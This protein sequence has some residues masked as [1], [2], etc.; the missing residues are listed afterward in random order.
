MNWNMVGH[1]WA[2]RVLSEHIARGRSKHAYLF[3]GPQGIGK[4]TL[5]LSFFKAI[6]CLAPPQAGQMCNACSACTRIERMEHPD[7]DLLQAEQE[8]GNLRVDQI[9]AL[10]RNLS[11]TPYEAHYRMA[12]LLRFEE[13]NPHA[14]N[15]LLKTLEEP[16]PQVVL[17]LTAESAE[18]LLPTIVS[19][20]EVVRLGPVPLQIVREGLQNRWDLSAVEADLLAHLSGGRVGYALQ[21]HN[22]PEKLEQRQSW[23]ND[24]SQ[25]IVSGRVA[26][27][28]YVE[29]LVKDK[30]T[31]R[32]VLQ[33]WLSYW[34][35][36]MLRASHASAPLI[37]LDRAEE[38]ENISSKI[39]LQTAYQT[40]QALQLTIAHLD[41]NVNSRLAVEVLVLDLP[42]LGH[43]T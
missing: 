30:E 13:A 9:R 25:L 33:L 17:I 40:V 42:G 5:A 19:R 6:N 28:T 3:T 27:F 41:S 29:N 16:S 15:A 1:E 32:Q 10:Q 4:R 24:L 39:D 20:C 34:R 7:L 35:D 26:R 23:L 12:L 36:I 8:G 37:N 14:A 21:L 22:A 38:I 31:A 18:R 2:V 11:L 43:L